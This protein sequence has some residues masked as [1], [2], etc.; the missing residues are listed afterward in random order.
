EQI[1]EELLEMPVDDVEGCAQPL[2]RLAVEVLDAPAQPLDRSA[3]IVALAREVRVLRADLAQLPLGAQIDRAEPLAV[4]PQFVE[5]GLDV[6]E[7][8]QRRTG[9]DAGKRRDAL[10]PDFEQLLN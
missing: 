4:A 5:L 3:Q 1:G 2:T 8:R 6:G 10:G 7:L 9:L